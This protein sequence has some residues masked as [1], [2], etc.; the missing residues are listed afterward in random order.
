MVGEQL[1]VLGEE[2]QPERKQPEWIVERPYCRLRYE[3]KSENFD[4]EFGGGRG[5]WGGFWV[6]ND[7]S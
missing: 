6:G 5:G 4:D 3:D 2:Q 7:N 1:P